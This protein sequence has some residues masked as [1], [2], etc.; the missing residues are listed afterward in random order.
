MGDL[1]GLSELPLSLAEP[2]LGFLSFGDLLPELQVGCGE[3]GGSLPHPRLQPDRGMLQ[4]L[5]GLHP[6]GYH[7]GEEERAEGDRRIKRLECEHLLEHR[8]GS[9]RPD[10]LGGRPR[11]DHHDEQGRRRR[12]PLLEPPGRPSQQRDHQEHQVRIGTDRHHRH[13][14]G[15]DE[16]HRGLEVLPAWSARSA[17]WLHQAEDERGDH[18]D[19]HGVACPPHRPGARQRIGRQR[20]GRHKD[21]CANRGA[22]A[23][24]QQGT[25]KDDGGGIS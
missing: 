2:P 24:T 3:L 10:P 11:G 17:P 20:S 13:R 12:P 9:E 6:L 21:P 16:Q 8:P 4:R 1:L 14:C 23:H 19:A 22:D 7:G 15:Q 25:D 5:M 18:E